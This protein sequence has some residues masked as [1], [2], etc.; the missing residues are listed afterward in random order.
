MAQGTRRSWRGQG[1]VVGVVA[2]GGGIGATARYG[3]SLLWPTPTGTF[4]WTTLLVNVVGCAL[5]GV[6]LVLIAEVWT[7]HRLMRPFLGTGVLGGF[8]TFSTY[9]VDFRRLVLEGHAASGA[10]Y[11]VVTPLAAMAAV[12]GAVAGTRRVIGVAGAYNGSTG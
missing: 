8:T 4:P 3:A 5:M 10:V 12:G 11:L 1:P 9:A 7:A 6:L 2:V